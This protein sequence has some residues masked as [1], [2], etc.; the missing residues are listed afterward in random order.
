[1]FYGRIKCKGGVSQLACFLSHCW[2]NPIQFPAHVPKSCRQMS[3]RKSRGHSC[4]SNTNPGAASP[5]QVDE[6]LA[7]G[8]LKWWGMKCRLSFSTFSRE[9]KRKFPLDWNQRWSKISVLS[10]SWVEIIASL[11]IMISFSWKALLACLLHP[12]LVFS[13][14]Q[15]T[16]LFAQLHNAQL[17]WGFLDK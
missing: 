6:D 10:D 7:S 5:I 12:F 9:G 3:A 14:D 13:V 1:M 4:T 2:A 17:G 16:F 8:E 11:L 15:E